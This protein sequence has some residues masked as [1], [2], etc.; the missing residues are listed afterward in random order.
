LDTI[1]NILD[2][3]LFRDLALKHDIAY[4]IAIAKLRKL[5]KI[6]QYQIEGLSERHLRRIET[7]KQHA[8]IKNLQALSTAHNMKLNDYLNKL[9]VYAGAALA[10]LT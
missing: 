2:P 6:R 5:K 9:A 8:S 10:L 3:K 7:G 4:G 1:K